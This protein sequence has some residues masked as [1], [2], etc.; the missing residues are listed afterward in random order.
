VAD[1]RFGQ[2]L[3]VTDFPKLPLQSPLHSETCRVTYE[4]YKRIADL[5]EFC[6]DI[7]NATEVDSFT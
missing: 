2:N 1:W 6:W 4:R 3:S 7:R 5:P